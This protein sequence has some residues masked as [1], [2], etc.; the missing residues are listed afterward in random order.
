MVKRF[1]FTA[2]GDKHT[3]KA[4]SFC[5]LQGSYIPHSPNETLCMGVGNLC[6]QIISI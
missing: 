5:F 2:L 3:Q 4:L 6:K 1:K